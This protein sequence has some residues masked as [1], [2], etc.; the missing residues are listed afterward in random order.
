MIR[1]ALVAASAVRAAELPIHHQCCKQEGK[2]N[3]AAGLLATTTVIAKPEDENVMDAGAKE[4]VA[5][6]VRVTMDL[7]IQEEGGKDQDTT[8]PV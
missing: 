6:W 5:S 3:S 4:L 7:V 8:A 1:I 2:S